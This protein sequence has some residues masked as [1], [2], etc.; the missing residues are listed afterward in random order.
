MI[1][2]KVG[3]LFGSLSRQFSIVLWSFSPVQDGIVGR[4]PSSKTASNTSKY[5]NFTKTRHDGPDV[6]FDET[7]SGLAYGC[8]GILIAKRDLSGEHF[9]EDDAETVDVDLFI[10]GL[11]FHDLG[12]HP[13]GCSEDAVPS[14]LGLEQRRRVDDVFA[15]VR[16]TKV[17][18]FDGEVRVQ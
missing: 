18:H 6:E 7:W 13:L 4:A 10:V 1:C 15:H 5:C 9:G 17:C 2:I 16:E 8:D 14:A 12:R 11:P 3:R